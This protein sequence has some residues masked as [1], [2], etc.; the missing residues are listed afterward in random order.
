MRPLLPPEPLRTQRMKVDYLYLPELGVWRLS[1]SE[2][3]CGDGGCRKLV[4]LG[5]MVHLYLVEGHPD[6]SFFT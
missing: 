6:I 4:N 5:E 1:E 3:G 2:S